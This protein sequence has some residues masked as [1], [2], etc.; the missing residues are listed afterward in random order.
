MEFQTQVHWQV[1]DPLGRRKY[2]NAEERRRFLSA[3]D[4]AVRETRALGYVL[5]FTGCRIS[6]ALALTPEHLDARTGTLTFRT[7]KRRRPSFRTIPVPPIVIGLLVDLQRRPGHRYWPMHRT[8]AWRHV[9]RL[10]SD[11]RIDGPMACCRG[12]RHGFGIHAATSNV[13]PGLIQRFMGHAS[14]S[15]TAI[16]IDAVGFEERQFAQRMW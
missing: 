4:A 16:Y 15:T 10:A 7:L 2:L 6:E 8:T 11:A 3:A 14:S 12:L 1:Y 13:P 9:K 5:A